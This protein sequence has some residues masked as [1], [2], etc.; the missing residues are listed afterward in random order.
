MYCLLVI[1]LYQLFEFLHLVY[2]KIYVLS[3]SLVLLFMY[4]F[5]LSICP[6]ELQLYAFVLDSISMVLQMDEPFKA[7]VFLCTISLS[8]V[9]FS[10]FT[11]F[12]KA[13]QHHSCFF[14][15]LSPKNSLI[16]P[17]SLFFTSLLIWVNHSSVNQFFSNT[18]APIDQLVIVLS[19]MKYRL[20]KMFILRQFKKLLFFIYL[21]IIFTNQFFL[22]VGRIQCSKNTFT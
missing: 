4:Y 6:R 12:P 14:V 7:F 19:G 5:S 20:R 1:I 18:L 9:F 10:Q 17:F 16:W 2:Q 8:I 21:N 13:W 22:K 11:V 3:R 15:L